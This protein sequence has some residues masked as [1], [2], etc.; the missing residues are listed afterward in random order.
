MI[1]ICPLDR[2]PWGSTESRSVACVQI[3]GSNPGPTTHQLGDLGQVTKPPKWTQF[4][5]LQNVLTIR[6]SE[7]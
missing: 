4:P 3:L 2:A 7:H 1:I 6:E 5:H